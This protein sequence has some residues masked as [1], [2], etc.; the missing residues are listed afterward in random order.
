MSN[1]TLPS[2]LHVVCELKDKK[3]YKVYYGG[4]QPGVTDDVTFQTV[5]DVNDADVVWQMKT[6]RD[7]KFLLIIP[8]IYAIDQKKVYWFLF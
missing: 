4:N 5:D 8:F 7:F 6:F 2:P 3:T 1:E